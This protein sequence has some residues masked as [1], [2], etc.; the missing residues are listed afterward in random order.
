MQILAYEIFQELHGAAPVTEGMRHLQA[1]PPLIHINFQ[2]N[3]VGFNSPEIHARPLEIGMNFPGIHRLFFQIV[4]EQPPVK[5]NGKIGVTL[6]GVHKSGT[7]GLIFN[8]VLQHHRKSEEARI[9]LAEN[10]RPYFRGVV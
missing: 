6:H 2:K 7:Q 10:R 3:P 9:A 8:P 5:L 1:D 4:P